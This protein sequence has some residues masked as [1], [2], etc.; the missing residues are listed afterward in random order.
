MIMANKNIFKNA[1]YKGSKHRPVADTVN[2]AGG[3]AYKTTD[4]HTLAQFAC[5]G[6][7]HNTFYVNAKNQLD[8]IKDI[9]PRINP[10]FIGKVAVYSRKKG[11]MKDM[12]AFLVA[13]LSCEG[14]ND[15]FK[16]VFPLVIDNGKMLRNFVQFVRSGIFSRNTLASCAKRQV[17]KWFTQKDGNYIFS[18][19]VG[20]NPSLADVIKL[21]HPRP[22]T[23]E[24]NAL[25]GYVL[26]KITEK[27]ERWVNL[28]SNV[29][30]YEQ[31]KNDTTGEV[32]NVPFQF[33]SSLELPE[34]VWKDIA[35]NGGWHMVRM[36]LN[37]FKRHGVLEDSAIVQA[38]ADKL[39]DE[40]QIRKSR[41]FPYQLF[42]AFQYA[43]DMPHEIT[44]ALQDA[45][46]ISLSNIPFLG[47]NVVVCPDVSGSMTWGGLT[48][49]RGSATSVVRPI[50]VAALVAAA[51]LRKH[52]NARVIPFECDVR[53]VNLNSRDSVMTNAQKLAR[54]GGGGTNVSAPLTL[55]NREKAEVDTVI[56]VSDNES[57]IDRSYGRYAQT[58]V[59]TEWN[60]IV[61]RNPNA[62]LFCI[63]TEPNTHT[64]AKDRED[65]L[66]IGGFS[67]QVF[68]VIAAFTEG[69]KNHWVDVI[70]KIDF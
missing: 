51:V 1:N 53:K 64:Q 49:F 34:R 35:L 30:A 24:Q 16:K 61:R 33:L 57:W 55:L 4:K 5:T 52:S 22:K 6:T 2:N 46:D 59:Q 47:K 32:P 67:D 20:S 63:D 19:S 3:C 26:G 70:E 62:K 45:L 56:I 58:N 13:F 21:S 40:D 65:I 28:P 9:L 41:V 25:F 10:E 12:P 37:T 60:K 48:G 17:Q 11:F 14:Y 27:D 68:N 29:L 50:D 23:A 15:V 43:K 42:T 69:S 31:F 44:E 54:I 38:I 18:Q 8:T 7:F 66:N 39:R 36:N